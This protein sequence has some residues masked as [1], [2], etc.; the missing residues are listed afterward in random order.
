MAGCRIGGT[1]T[2]LTE[3]DAAQ[4]ER[5]HRW[6]Q[7]VPG[8]PIVLF[9]VATK[10][11]PEYY[12]DA[13]IDAVNLET[14][15]R[16]NVFTGASF[17]RYVPSGHLVFGRDGSLW[18]VP[19]DIEDLVTTGTPLPVQSDVM[20]LRN[21]GVVF[22]SIALNG[23]LAFV[24]GQPE[25]LRR[26]IVWRHFDGR[27]EPIDAI[28]V[29]AVITVALSPD[30]NRVAAAVSGATTHDIW[31]FDLKR[32][33]RTR[34]TF[35]GDN[36]DP[37]WTPDGNSVI[38]SSTRDGL[39]MAFMKSADGTGDERLLWKVD[40]VTVGAE[41][42]S[43]DGRIALL[44]YHGENKADLYTLALDDPSA[45][46]QPLIASPAEDDLARFSPD[47]RWIAYTTDESGEFEVLVRPASGSGGQW[48]VSTGAGLLPRWSRDGKQLFYR[49]GRKLWVV[50]VEASD[51]ASAF[52]AGT[53]RLLFDDFD[54][55]RMTSGYDVAPDGK[56]VLAPLSIQED[57]PL[58]RITVLVN[59]LDEV[60]R[61]VPAGR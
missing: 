50:D 12:D 42:V 5:T 47:G 32:K 7:I 18:A 1:P 21:S 10:D 61:I 46:P 16:K 56:A 11:S 8:H 20:G 14:G 57:A 39:G 38:Y 43:S 30:A 4:R 53:P 25:D 29:G 6:P 23:M 35:E 26:E 36:S 3:L 24:E 55:S 28:P 51:D 48:Q 45:E 52:R 13:R 31:V 37:H 34:L 33:N 41:D 54:R 60:E 49:I 9:T 27:T 2:P 44:N 58:D 22:A 17:A 40:G 15:E 59:W 19:F